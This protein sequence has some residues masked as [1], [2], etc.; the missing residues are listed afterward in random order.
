MFQTL[1]VKHSGLS[2]TGT[3]LTGC[4]E[5]EIFHRPVAASTSFPA[6][7]LVGNVFPVEWVLPKV[8]VAS[9]P[10]SSPQKAG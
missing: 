8:L 2:Q 5:G 6:L 7:A 1:T 3:G 10:L 4:N 9:L